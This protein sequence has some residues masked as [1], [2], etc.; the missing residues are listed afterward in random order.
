MKLT[1]RTE[2]TQKTTDTQLVELQLSYSFKSV[3]EKQIQK[4]QTLLQMNSD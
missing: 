3:T 2:A 4:L 1:R